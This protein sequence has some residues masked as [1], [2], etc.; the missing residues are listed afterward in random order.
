M[1]YYLGRHHM[2][3]DVELGHKYRDLIS[4]FEGI[5]VSRHVYLNGCIRVTLGGGV[6]ESGKVEDQSFDVQQLQWVDNGV[7]DALAP[8]VA[9][10]VEP[11]RATGGPR[12]HTPPA[13]T[14]H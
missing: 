14:G 13:R 12:D 10:V 9:E 2:L 3:Q 6:L 11:R 8:P 1:H 7:A 4:G 5:A